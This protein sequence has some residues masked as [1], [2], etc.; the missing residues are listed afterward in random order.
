[1]DCTRDLAR[2]GDIQ[3]RGG[4]FLVCDGHDRGQLRVAQL[5]LRSGE[6]RSRT[7]VFTGAIPFGDEPPHAAMR[8]I[9][10]GVRPPRPT[11]PTLTDRLWGLTQRCWDQDDRRRP[12]ALRISCSL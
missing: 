2:P 11:D 4:C 1:M 8:A 10:G 7:K 9:V 5:G 12:R 3:Q 6:L